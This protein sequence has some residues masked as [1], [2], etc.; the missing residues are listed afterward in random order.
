MDRASNFF[1]SEDG[2]KTLIRHPIKNAMYSPSRKYVISYLV[3]N[4]LVMHR[5]KD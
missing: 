3:G 1:S 4:I 2:Y 5:L